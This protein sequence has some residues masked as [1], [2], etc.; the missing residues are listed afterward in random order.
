MFT[1]KHLTNAAKLTVGK[2]A[3][4]AALLLALPATAAV[5]LK[6][7]V[8]DTEFA[9]GGYMKVDAFWSDFSDGSLASNNIGRQFYVP[10]TVPVC[11]SQDCEDGATTFD[12]HTRATR[13]NFSTLTHIDGHKVKTF[14][15]MDFLATPGGNELVSNSYSPR[16]RHAFISYDNWLVGQT[17]TTFQN[18]GALP[19]S[20][21]F[22]G[23]AESTIFERQAMV[24]YSYGN[25][26]FSLE[27]P[28]SLVM[29]NG[30][31]GRIDCDDSS[32]PDMVARYN[33]DAGW[34]QLSVAALL[35]QLKIDDANYDSTTSAYGV[36]VAGKIKLGADDIRFMGSYGSGMG[37][38]IGLAITSDAVLDDKG[39]LEAIDSYG[40]FV[41]YRHLWNEKLRSTLSYSTFSADNKIEYTGRSATKSADSIHLN[42]IYSPIKPLS[43]GVEYIRANRELENGYDGDLDR[44]QFSAKYVL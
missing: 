19:E 39:D 30:G 44:L 42:L 37:R 5:K 40:G 18:T 8:N 22:L 10:S 3:L 17:W 43:I 13:F 31:N 11:E 26:Q 12:G 35:R 14:L 2:S 21:D 25:W 36:S 32:L 16:L 6:D 9:F 27:N 20:L 23:P 4:A 1:N 41:A 28:E 38:Y 15:E 29:N 7:A 33:H 34:G 24:R